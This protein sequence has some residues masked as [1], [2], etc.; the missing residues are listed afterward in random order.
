MVHG[1]M[2]LL[3]VV[4]APHGVM[5]LV[6][7][8]T[9]TEDPSHISAYGPLT[10]GHS[11]F[12]VT[13]V[14]V[15][16]AD[17]VIAK[18]DGLSSRTESERLRGKRLY[19]RRSSLPKLQE[20]EF[21]ENELIGMDAKLEDGTTYGVIS[22]ILNF[23]SCDIIELSTSTGKLVMVPFSRSTFPVVDV[24][25]RVVIVVPPEVIGVGSR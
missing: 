7:V 12:N 21:Y 5:G 9:F 15:L 1:D 14:S 20:D 16:G 6:K 17:S 23:G 11:C 4:R 18:F 2:V 3:G 13:V 19:V 22:A 25:R 10:D 8:R 24:E